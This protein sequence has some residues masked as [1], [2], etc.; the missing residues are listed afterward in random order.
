AAA[1]NG[2]TADLVASAALVPHF[3][4]IAASIFDVAR[5]KESRGISHTLGLSLHWHFHIH[6]LLGHQDVPGLGGVIYDHRSAM[7]AG[8]LGIDAHFIL[9]KVDLGLSRR[10]GFLQ[11]DYIRG[12]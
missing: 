8:R 7:G 5:L 9:G 4:P 12:E 11:V 10:A 1:V 6:M 2:I 3:L